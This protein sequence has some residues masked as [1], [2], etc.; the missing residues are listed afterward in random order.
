VPSFVFYEKEKALEWANEMNNYPKVFKLRGG[1]GSQ[2]VKLVNDKKA[3]VALINR[4]FDKGFSLVDRSAWLKQ[5]IWIYRRDGGLKNFMRIIKSILSLPG[6]TLNE[7]LLPLQKGYAYFQDFVPGNTYDDRLIVIGNRCFCVRRHCRKNDF[8]ASGS[9]VKSYDHH[10]FPKES[11]QIAYDVAERI[12][13]QSATLDFIYDESRRP[14]ICEISYG[15]ITGSFYDDCD[16]LFDR[17]IIWH[18]EKV[19]PQYF[20]M[21]DFI[22]LITAKTKV[23]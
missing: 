18:A 4:A 1:A 3:A 19:N 22:E 14:L 16:G 15:F 12:R 17:E 5:A 8:R 23:R 7:R 6:S 2:N 21:E 10:L 9:G 13:S 11:I 20:I